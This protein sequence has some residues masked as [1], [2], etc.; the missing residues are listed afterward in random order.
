MMFDIT[1]HPKWWHKN[2]GICFTGDFFNDIGYRLECDIKM[3]KVLHQKFGDFGIGEKN[4]KK[5]PILGSDLIAAG[6]LFSTV[7]GCKVIFKEGDSPNVICSNADLAEY[8]KTPPIDIKRAPAFVSQIRQAQKL[9]TDFGYVLPCINLMGVQNIALDI[10]GDALFIEYYENEDAVRRLLSYITDLL[11]QG[12]SCLA[13]FNTEI[14]AGV[15][16]IVN[17]TVRDVFVTSNCSV[18]M[19]SPDIYRSFLLECDIKLS[20]AH[21]NFGI[22]HCGKSMQLYSALYAEVPNLTF[23][24]AGAGSDVAA[25]RRDMP[26]VF[27]NARYSPVKLLTANEEE[28]KRDIFKLYNDGKDLNGNNISISCVGIGDNVSDTAVINFLKACKSVDDSVKI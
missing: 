20:K 7:A 8:L 13:S 11:F 5:R 9:I 10:L 17:K 25:V 15:T 19:V 3:R 28:I 16:S 21:K 2:A 18:D 6:Y 1:F 24:E 27:I 14:S 23:A 22:H 12:V 4:P 26:S